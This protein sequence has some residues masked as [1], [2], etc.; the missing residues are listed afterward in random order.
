MHPARRTSLRLDT[1][2]TNFKI[3]NF[4]LQET[5]TVLVLLSFGIWLQCSSYHDFH[6]FVHLVHICSQHINFLSVCGPT[7]A[8]TIAQQHLLVWVYRKRRVHKWVVWAFRGRSLIQQKAICSQTT[9]CHELHTSPQLDRAN[10]WYLVRS[11]SIIWFCLSIKGIIILIILRIEILQSRLA[12]LT[13]CF[14]RRL[15]ST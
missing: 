2:S 9:Y 3:R 4:L 1:A 11:R 13:T 8:K 7:P 14:L 5:F 12:I 6:I 10:K 15:P